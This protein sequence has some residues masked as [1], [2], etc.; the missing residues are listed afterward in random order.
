MMANYPGCGK[1]LL[2]MMANFPRCL[3]VVE[4]RLLKKGIIYY[5]CLDKGGGWG[6]AE[7]WTEEDNKFSVTFYILLKYKL[8]L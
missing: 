5:N 4:E 7:G 3:S 6:G 1:D 2:P 8:I